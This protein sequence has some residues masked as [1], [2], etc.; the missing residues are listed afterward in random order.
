M[1]QTKKFKFQKEI[2][3]LIRNRR[4]IPDEFW[5][6]TAGGTHEVI[7]FIDR[8]KPSVSQSYDFD[9]ERFG[10]TKDGKI[11]WGFDSGCSCPSPWE[12]DQRAG[13]E[14]KEWKEF[15]VSPVELDTDWQDACFDNL[16]DYLL[17]VENNLDP[18][19]VITAKNAEV[20][21]FLMKRVGYQEVKDAVNAEVV[22]I[23]G[24]SEL[25]K[26]ADGDM[27]VKVKD[28]STEREYLLYV[29]SHLKTCRAAIAWTFGLSEQEYRP[30]IET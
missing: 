16:K 23:D 19:L 22:H 30:V 11:I 2:E 8:Q 24:T 21:R 13:Y 15:V 4:K 5:R 25:L 14:T 29:P 1:S 17:V 10:V 28:S 6:R 3:R 26:F 7:W 9:M 18:K 20:R 12:D 27:Y